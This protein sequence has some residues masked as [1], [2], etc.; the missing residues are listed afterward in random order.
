MAIDTEFDANRNTGGDRRLIL[1]LI[2]LCCA[3]GAGHSIMASVDMKVVDGMNERDMHQVK[4]ELC[5]LFVT[6][7]GRMVV[8]GFKQ[9]KKALD[10]VGI[11]PDNT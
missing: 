11:L 9:D 5:D 6:R 3:V 10:R 7:L 1:H 2:C 8:F 4:V